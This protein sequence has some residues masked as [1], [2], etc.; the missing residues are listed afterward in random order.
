MKQEVTKYLRTGIGGS[1]TWHINSRSPDGP[2]S[3]WFSVSTHL[4]QQMVKSMEVCVGGTFVYVGV[5]EWR[6][7]W[8][9]TKRQMVNWKTPEKRRVSAWMMYLPLPHSFVAIWCMHLISVY[10]SVRDDHL[11]LKYTTRQTKMFFLNNFRYVT[12]TL[13]LF[14]YYAPESGYCSVS[15]LLLQP[16]SQP[17]ILVW[18]TARRRDQDEEERTLTLPKRQDRCQSNSTTCA[19]IKHYC[20]LTFHMYCN[21]AFLWMPTKKPEKGSL[22]LCCLRINLLFSYFI[23][24]FR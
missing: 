16:A 13:R 17:A 6:G 10:D 12:W 11:V 2:C 5:H 19:D 18:A 8:Q 21:S 20:I 1:P 14:L 24:P 9:V 22:S 15:H 7:G 23:F 4:Q 3:P